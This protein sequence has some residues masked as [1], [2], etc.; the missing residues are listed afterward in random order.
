MASKK[1][2]KESIIEKI[3]KMEQ[4]T[5]LFP[6]SWSD[7]VDMIDE[8]WKYKT[9]NSGS[10]GSRRYHNFEIYEE[11]QKIHDINFRGE[12]IE[13]TQDL[14]KKAITLKEVEYYISAIYEEKH[15]FKNHNEGRRRI[16]KDL[17]QK[18]KDLISIKEQIEV[19]KKKLFDSKKKI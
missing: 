15:S 1:Q 8:D 9:Y 16:R 5:F 14:E 13:I 4:N 11:G 19:L 18:R 6:H 17:D 2:L 7:E 12:Q 3:E 10:T